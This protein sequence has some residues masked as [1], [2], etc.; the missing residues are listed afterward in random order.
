MIQNCQKKTGILPSYDDDV[1]DDS[2]DDIN[3]QDF[4]V[5]ELDDIDL[6]D[7]PQ[8]DNLREYFQMLDQE[9]PTEEYL[10]ENQIIN[11]VQ[12]EENEDES[13]TDADADEEIPLVFA[14][15]SVN[16]LKTFINYFE[17]QNEEDFSMDDLSI[18][19]KYLRIV[20]TKEFNTRTQKTLDMYFE[21][22]ELVYFQ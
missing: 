5:D 18:F 10:F 2:A 14:K 6:D 1:D 13:D 9:I 16:A 12:G 15:N 3:E 21:K 11:L 22:Q 7:L 8:A 4:E 19:Q 20:K 17:Q